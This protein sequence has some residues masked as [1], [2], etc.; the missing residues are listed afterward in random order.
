VWSDGKTPLTAEDF[1]FGWRRAMAVGAETAELAD[2]V[3]VEQVIAARERP[4]APEER[5]ARVGA[6][7]AGVGVEAVDALTFRVTLRS[8]RSYFLARVANT[9][10][11]FPAPSRDLQGKSEEAVHRYF[12]EPAGGKPMVVGAFLVTGWDRVA[13]RVELAQNPFAADRPAQGAVTRLTFLQS[14]LSPVLY[15]QCRVDLLLMDDPASLA[16]APPDTQRSR[17]LSVYW[18][19]MNT[20][21]LSLPLRQ[22]ISHALDR[23][24][25]TQGLLPDAR[26]ALT[27][28]PPDM[29]GA[30]SAD[31]PLAAP[32]PRY[33]P[34][35]ARAE[36][37][38]SG[39]RGEELTLL[40][41][42]AA[43]FMP[44]LGIAEAVRVQLAELGVKVRV[45]PTGNFVN[46]VEARDG[47]LRHHLFLRRTGADYPHPQTLF[48]VFLPDGNHYTDWQKL[49]GGAP[50]AE[51]QAL[52]D[53]GAAETDPARMRTIFARA[54][55][56][57]LAREAVAVPL[58]Y[59]DRYYRLRPWL[60]GLSVD[61]FNFLTLRD[62]RVKSPAP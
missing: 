21:K 62:A 14:E 36:L 1:A 19:G 61:P 9:Y 31:D 37:A 30:L 44:E 54:E 25:L 2:I 23:G 60:T 24:K 32:L 57:L 15:A 35:R 6:A 28:L 53:A 45:V 43:T 16:H 39:Y 5:A 51:F 26:A 52:L 20:S 47:S 42:D 12:D 46:D 29:P 34:A 50:L 17:L 27:F 38:A 55:E 33:D 11:F 22:A 41:K 3:G 49:G 4:G 7:L 10:P 8:P 56:L 48:T 40:V 18:L 13:Q 59:P 58:Y